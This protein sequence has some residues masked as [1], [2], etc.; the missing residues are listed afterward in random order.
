MYEPGLRVPLL[1]RGPGIKKGVV[2]EEFVANIDLAPT[3]P[4]GGA[5]GPFKKFEIIGEKTTAG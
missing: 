3:W 5:D 2:P 4:K 1:A